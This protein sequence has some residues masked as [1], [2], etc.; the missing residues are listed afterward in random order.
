[1]SDETQPVE[2]PVESA[3]VELAR[4][5]DAAAAAVVGVVRLYSATPGVVRTAKQLTS[6]ES[7]PL[8]LS[9][10][11]SGAD[12]LSVTVCI[13]VSAASRDVARSVADAV[14]AALTPRSAL[15]HVRVSRIAAVPPTR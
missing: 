4:V 1:M 15:V 3:G 14:R 9:A 13:E 7:V 8:P 6:S 12:G 11:S 5:V 2:H 10:V